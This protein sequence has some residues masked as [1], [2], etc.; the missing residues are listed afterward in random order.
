M[1]DT[2]KPPIPRSNL[3]APARLKSSLTSVLQDA[4]PV[5]IASEA[6]M[7]S[8]S[9]RSRRLFSPSLA[10][11]LPNPGGTAAISANRVPIP[12]GIAIA[13]CHI[14]KISSNFSW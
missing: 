1:G 10:T 3:C 13:A 4:L 2:G 5:T 12:Y 14:V 8:R 7:P 6:T 9:E 11:N